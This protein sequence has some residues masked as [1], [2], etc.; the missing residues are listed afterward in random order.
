M[1]RRV[2]DIGTINMDEVEAVEA[3]DIHSKKAVVFKQYDLGSAIWFDLDVDYTDLEETLARES[4]FVTF[5]L[6]NSE[7][8]EYEI[9]YNVEG[10]PVCVLCSDIGNKRLQLE[11]P[12]DIMNVPGKYQFE[13]VIVATDRFRIT[14]KAISFSII[15]SIKSVDYQPDVQVLPIEDNSYE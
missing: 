10:L 13:I 15:P 6:A 5:K 8:A 11:P 14:S 1:Y 2:R 3:I 12:L 7:T 4:V 9:V